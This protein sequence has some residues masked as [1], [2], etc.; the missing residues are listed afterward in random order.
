MIKTMEKVLF[1]LGELDD[2][3]L[4][5]MLA[6]GRHERFAAGH[7][8]IHEQ[9]PIDALYILLD[10][11]LSVSTLAT[12]GHEIAILSSGEVVGEMSFVDTRPPSAT[13]TVKHPSLVLAIPRDLLVA[14][15]QQDVAFASRFYR[16][17]AVFLSTRLRET[18]SHL[19]TVSTESPAT[20]LTQEARDSFALAQ[21]RLDWLLRRVRDQ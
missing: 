9:H 15:L 10:G 6:V 4:D 2:D 3:D 1:I 18:A 8:L 17:L 7:I 20:E 14:K 12:G 11:E 21:T 16:A 5:W 19:G 13:V